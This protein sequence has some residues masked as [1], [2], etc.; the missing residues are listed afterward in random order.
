VVTR[1]EKDLTE[2]QLITIDLDDTLW[3]C[4][5]TIMAAETAL[6]DWLKRHARRLAIAHDIA[7][8]RLH[9]LA[10]KARLPAIGHDLT[11]LRLYS[12]RELLRDF[13]Y[14]AALADTAVRLFQGYRNRV[15]P[16][17]EVSAA[18]RRLACRYR[19]ISLSNGNA[20][21]ERTPLR[22]HFDASLN[23][24]DVG[25]SKPDPALFVSALAWAGL[26]AAAALHVGDDPLLDVE[27]ARALGMKTA[28]VNRAQR[29]WPADLPAPDVAVR[30][31]D[32]LQTWL[33]SLA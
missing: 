13:G 6:H 4:Q 33:E 1:R 3:P 9:R 28:W 18:L 16:Y 24:A 29:R 25:A 10:L 12:L 21:V 19:L 20:E 32:E 23:A 11:A 22:G 31:L 27:A 26:D 14:D 7:S 17:A 8:L 30:H 2:I 5:P 15:Q